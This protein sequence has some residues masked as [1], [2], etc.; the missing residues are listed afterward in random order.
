MSMTILIAPS[1]FK[2]S[3]T[4]DEATTYIAA[5][6]VKAMPDATILKAPM[7]DG[8]EVSRMHWSS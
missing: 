3:L 8:G 4:A 2:E 1:G 7:V 6:V 5:G